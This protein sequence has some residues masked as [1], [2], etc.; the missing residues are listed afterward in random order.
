M[1]RKDREITNK[2]DMIQIIEN[3]K[4]ARI[5]LF[6]DD[7]PYNPVSEKTHGFNRADDSEHI[8]FFFLRRW[9]VK[10]ASTYMI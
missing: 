1:R 7:Y 3:A 10:K 5:A 9:K 2:E 4:I 8:F 6:D